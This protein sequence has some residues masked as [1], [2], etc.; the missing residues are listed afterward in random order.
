MP[1]MLTSHAPDVDVATHPVIAAGELQV[2]GA[3]NHLETSPMQAS[4][5]HF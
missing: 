5:T 3:W 4:K 1:P 2:S